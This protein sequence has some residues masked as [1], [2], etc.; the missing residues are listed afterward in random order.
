M[1]A[2]AAVVAVSRRQ[3]TGLLS[4]A[5]VT[6]LAGAGARG[7]LDLRRGHSDWAERE[8]G[9]SVEGRPVV[10]HEAGEGPVLIVIGALHGDEP[11]SSY[12]TRGL[13]HVGRQMRDAAAGHRVVIIPAANPD[14][15]SAGTRGN[16]RRVDIN[17]NFP[18]GNWTG[19]AAGDRFSPGPS[20][21]SEPETQALVALLEV[22]RPTAIIAL[23]AP[24]RLVNYDGPAREMAEAMA[25]R[26]G[27]PVHDDIGYSTPGSLGTYAGV[28][29][30]IPVVTLELPDAGDAQ[31]WRENRDALLAGL[32]R[33]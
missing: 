12:C 16:A 6:V 28:E 29:R 22:T 5:V 17:R 3:A 24:M 32:M 30:G 21:G 10:A 20:P 11:Q 1:R 31:C 26:N 2:E 14:G 33:P 9:R 27:Y 18:T 23:H 25:A 8:I 4:L 13:L 19:D 15:L 7:W